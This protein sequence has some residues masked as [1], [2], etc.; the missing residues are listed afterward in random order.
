MDV[1]QTHPWVREGAG[2]IR[3]GVRVIARAAEVD[4]PTRRGLAQAV[5]ALGFDSLWVPDH[6]AFLT[7]P[8]TALA[9]YATATSRVR[10]GPM[11][12]CVAHRSPLM[13]ARLAADVDRLS[14][15]P[16]PPRR[17]PPRAG[18]VETEPP[19]PGLRGVPPTH[20]RRVTPVYT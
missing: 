17:G 3:F 15:G 8:W 6:P 11:V 19:I 18:W 12:S 13:T 16:L 1:W 4:W 7:D 10:I 2:K 20:G 14:G 5:D 9:A